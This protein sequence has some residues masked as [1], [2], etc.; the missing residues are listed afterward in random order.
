MDTNGTNNQTI[1]TRDNQAGPFF[2]ADKDRRN[3]G[4]KTRQIIQPEHPHSAPPI[5]IANGREEVDG[6]SSVFPPHFVKQLAY[7]TGL[8]GM[9]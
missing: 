7:Q 4:E 3:D 1:D 5:Q 9:R 8:A 6:I 2:L